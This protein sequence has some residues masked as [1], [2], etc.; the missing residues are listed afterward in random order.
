VIVA[1]EVIKLAPIDAADAPALTAGVFE[2]TP[3]ELID[4]IVTEEGAYLP[5]EIGA[6]VDRTPFLRDGY[7]LLRSE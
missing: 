7:S 2:L 6:L 4:S 5:E 1:C 3:P